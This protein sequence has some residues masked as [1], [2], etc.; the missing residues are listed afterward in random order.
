MMEA[1]KAAHNQNKIKRKKSKMQMKM[2]IHQIRVK[3]KR[4]EIMIAPRL[5]PL[6]ERNQRVVKCPAQN[7][8]LIIKAKVVPKKMAKMRRMT[9]HPIVEN[10]SLRAAKIMRRAEKRP[11]RCRKVS[12]MKLLYGP[13]S[14]V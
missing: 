10:K 13:V 9:I 12:I 8:K 5:I 4:K 6:V 3:A 2:M 1:R 7:E 14:N 11:T